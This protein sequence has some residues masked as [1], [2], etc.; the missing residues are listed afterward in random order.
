MDF[1]VG[2]LVDQSVRAEQEIVSLRHSFLKEI[3]FHPAGGAKARVIQIFLG[4]V[5]GLLWGQVPFGHQILHHRVVPGNPPGW[6]AW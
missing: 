4:V 5:S 2:D 3:G 1:L 6:P